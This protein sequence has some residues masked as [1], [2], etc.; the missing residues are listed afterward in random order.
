MSKKIISGSKFLIPDGPPGYDGLHASIN[1]SDEVY[2]YYNSFED[3]SEP[4]FENQAHL[5]P[6]LSHLCAQGKILLEI[7]LQANVHQKRGRRTLRTV[8]ETVG[9]I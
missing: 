7:L 6:Q 9:D 5:N 4:L 1:I 2:D 3:A 8:H